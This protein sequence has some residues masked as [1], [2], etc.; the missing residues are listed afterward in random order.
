MGS[1]LGIPAHMAIQAQLHEKPGGI[2][3]ADLS[4]CS[5]LKLSLLNGEI[6]VRYEDEDVGAAISHVYNKDS[7]MQAIES[8]GR[9]LQSA[10]KY[11]VKGL[12]SLCEAQMKHRLH[13]HTAVGMLKFA[14]EVGLCDL[15]KTVL[16]Y[17]T[18]DEGTFRA[19]KDLHDFDSLELNLVREV[20]EAFLHPKYIRKRSR[21]EV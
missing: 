8:W 18:A 12:V 5:I 20:I 7:Y 13:L 21:T 15:K 2:W 11:C 10:D 6:I 17:I 14:N 9:L 16:T 3:Q 1:S 4:D 19:V